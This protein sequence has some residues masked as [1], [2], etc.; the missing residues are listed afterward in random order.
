[1]TDASG[2]NSTAGIAETQNNNAAAAGSTPDASGT[3]IDTDGVSAVVANLAV[4]EPPSADPVE[5]AGGESDASDFSP[6]IQTES[7]GSS[8]FSLMSD[9]EQLAEGDGDEDSDMEEMEEMDHA[10]FLEEIQMIAGALGPED[11]VDIPNGAAGPHPPATE[12]EQQR[13]TAWYEAVPHVC[14]RLLS[15]TEAELRDKIKVLEGKKF[16][17]AINF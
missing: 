7:D 13:V 14:D 12:E 1:M 3:R 10:A 11:A 5:A 2:S 6:V 15:G 9:E 17:T 8:G 16:W 4:E